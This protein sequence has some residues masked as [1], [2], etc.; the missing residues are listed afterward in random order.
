LNGLDIDG[1]EVDGRAVPIFKLTNG[2]AGKLSLADLDRLAAR[3][4][5]KGIPASLKGTN[6][7][8]RKQ[9]AQRILGAIGQL[10]GYP[11]WLL[12]ITS[13]K[14]LR[15]TVPQYAPIDLWASLTWM[16]PA[17]LYTFMNRSVCQLPQFVEEENKT[18]QM[19]HLIKG[20]EL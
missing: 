8:G 4:K 7:A 12:T 3:H 17:L 20:T 13:S 15:Y 11:P 10:G 19:L 5:I 2:D 9:H 18:G 16:A 14:S 6:L 1:G